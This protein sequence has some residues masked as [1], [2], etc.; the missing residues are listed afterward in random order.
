MEQQV[1]CRQQDRFGGTLL[2]SRSFHHDSQ[3]PAQGVHQGLRGDPQ[4][5]LRDLR[6]L[7][8]DRHVLVSLHFL[9]VARH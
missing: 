3:A 8:A 7:R 1:V 4:T 5:N 2:F 9:L 6:I